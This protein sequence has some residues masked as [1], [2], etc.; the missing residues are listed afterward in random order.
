MIWII[1]AI[2]AIAAI[3]GEMFTLGLYLGSLALAA[4]A[5][6]ALS[7]VLAPPLQIAAFA[8]LALVLLL[9]VRPVVLPLLPFGEDSRA[10]PRV[11]P[12]GKQGT[13]TQDLESGGGQIR[14]GQGEFWSARP[15]NEGE[16]IPAGR[17]VEIIA[18]DGLTALVEQTEHPAPALEGPI[19]FGLS[20]REVEVLQLVADGLSNAE[21]AERL[22][23]SPRTV[24]HH[25]SHILNKMGVDSRVD[26]VRL[27][28]A[29][30]LVEISPA[31][32]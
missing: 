3:V 2:I 9:G 26:A 17:Q 23:L 11:G 10:L 22:F 8:V 32:E 31:Q 16:R 29:R 14:V 1:W 5:V 13:V 20:P 24:H 21:I 25:V 4:A 19:P 15:L 30:G 18:M 28:I 12:V 27:G 6:A 7:F